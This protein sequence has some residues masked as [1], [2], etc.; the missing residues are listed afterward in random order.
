MRDRLRDG[1]ESDMA[2]TWLELPIRYSQH[3]QTLSS[4][5]SSS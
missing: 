4:G 1:C 5:E 2:A 3:S